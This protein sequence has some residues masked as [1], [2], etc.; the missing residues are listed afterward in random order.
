MATNRRWNSGS[1][2]TRPTV[3][4]AD[5]VAGRIPGG[6]AFGGMLL[7]VGLAEA[8]LRAAGVSAEGVL[9]VV[10]AAMERALRAVSIERGVDPRGLALVAFGGAGPL[11]ACALAEALD[12]PAVIV[13][14]R[15]GVLSAVGLL[16][17]PVQRDLVRSWPTPGDHAALGTAQTALVARAAALVGPGAVTHTSLDCRYAGQSHEITVPSVADFHEAHR[18]RNGFARPE[19]AVEVIALRATASIASGLDV[20]DL[21]SV[22]RPSAT[23]PVAIAEPDC[24]IWIPDGWSSEPGAAGA[25]VLRRTT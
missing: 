19:A 1:T 16:T 18:L 12:M 15:A 23:G 24:T 3:T 13:P 17:S 25:L 2:R 6:V 8:A 20:G 21:P 7:D 5:L 9:Q 11:H 22:N 10:D 14:A 4:D